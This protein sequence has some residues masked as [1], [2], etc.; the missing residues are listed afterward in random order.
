VFTR[1]VEP[2]LRAV[3]EHQLVPTK[4]EVL[5]NVKLAVLQDKPHEKEVYSEQQFYGPYTALYSSTYGFDQKGA[6]IYE[7]F[8]NTGR[9]YYFPLLPYGTEELKRGDGSEVPL[10]NMSDMADK[11]KVKEAFDNA[12]KK[13]YDGDALVTMP[14][15]KVFIINTNE[16]KDI[17]QS[18]R[19]KNPG[20]T[21]LL[22]LEGKI[23]P[24]AYLI[25]KG[26]N[27]GRSFWMQANTAYP[28]RDTELKFEC[29]AEPDVKVVPA[30][31]LIKSEWDKK[32][33]A[34]DITLSHAEGAVEVTLSV[35]GLK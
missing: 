30:S 14:G 12:Y 4:E 6:D 28:D 29:I 17:T 27:D 33:G 8:P 7:Y 34:L 18:Y 21:K 32:T 20:N 19:I 16:N 3:A 22:S 24:H 31:G 25:G 26:E 35:E 23:G 10:V 5:E 13:E 2:F 1:Y 15:E 11:K 9:Y